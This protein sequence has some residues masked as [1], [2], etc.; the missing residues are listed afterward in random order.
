MILGRHRRM[1]LWPVMKYC[2]DI[3]LKGPRMIKSLIH[4]CWCIIPF[5]LVPPKCEAEVLPT[6]P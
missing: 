5:K 2:Y 1:W 3:C 6:T 4:K